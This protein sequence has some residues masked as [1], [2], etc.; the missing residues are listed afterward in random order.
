[1]A[2][3]DPGDRLATP[4]SNRRSNMYVLMKLRPRPAGAAGT[5]GR[6]SHYRWQSNF[7]TSGVVS[8]AVASETRA[9]ALLFR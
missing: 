4:A 9:S 3:H 7:G 2:D 5:L 1:M 8:K 6:H